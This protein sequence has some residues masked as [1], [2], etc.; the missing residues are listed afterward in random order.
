MIVKQTNSLLFCLNKLSLTMQEG[1]T[2][3][4]RVGGVTRGNR[5]G[6]DVKDRQGGL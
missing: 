6:R 2:T 3:S 1:L 5:W 4:E